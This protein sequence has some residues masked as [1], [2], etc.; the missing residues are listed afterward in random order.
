MH[1]C[2]AVAESNTPPDSVSSPRRKPG[3]NYLNPLRTLPYSVP[4]LYSSTSCGLLHNSSIYFTVA[5]SDR[6]SCSDHHCK[7]TMP[8]LRDPSQNVR[9]G[10]DFPCAGEVGRKPGVTEPKPPP[11]YTSKSRKSESGLDPSSRY[12]S[13][14]NSRQTESSGYLSS[15][16]SRQIESSRCLSSSNSRQPESSGYLSSSNSRQ[17]ESSHYSSQS[18]SSR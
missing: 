12:S 2:G 10:K 5:K 9:Q 15:S 3:L 8:E 13:N 18:Y 4:F 16:N 11:P 14:S 6:H 7:I 1:A 17:S